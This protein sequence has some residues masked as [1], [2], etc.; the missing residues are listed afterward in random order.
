MLSKAGMCALSLTGLICIILIRYRYISKLQVIDIPYQK[1]EEY[2]SSNNTII[3]DVFNLFNCS[4]GRRLTLVHERCLRQGRGPYLDSQGVLDHI[5]KGTMQQL[6]VQ[7][8]NK[9]MFCPLCKVA[10]STMKQLLIN[11]SGVNLRNISGHKTGKRYYMKVKGV[12]SITDYNLTGITQRLKHYHSFMTVRHPFDR[13][14]SAYYEKFS[15]PYANFA[16]KK[17]RLR[18]VIETEYAGKLKYEGKLPMITLAQFLELIAK[19][20]HEFTNAHWA[21]FMSHCDPCLLQFKQIL[22]LETMEDDL[23]PLLK[24]ITYPDGSDPVA[25]KPRRGHRIHID[26]L[27]QVTDVFRNISSDI[28]DGL[29]DIYRLDF[30]IFGYT[31]D[32]KKG[33][34]ITKID[35]EKCFWNEKTCYYIYY[36]NYV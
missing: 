8:R 24:R 7:D 28:I 18:Q 2:T 14:L 12:T 15:H 25:G 17:Q 21:S 19:R 34:G 32:K 36:V 6:L 11:T 1:Q 26:R 30:Q 23:V 3:D 22:R 4:M 31:W 29:M 16:A 10:S 33:A 20:Q 5:H 9:V 27:Q 13:L 35:N